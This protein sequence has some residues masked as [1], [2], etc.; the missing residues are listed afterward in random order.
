MA[1]T[2]ITQGRVCKGFYFNYYEDINEYPLLRAAMLDD[3]DYQIFAKKKAYNAGTFTANGVTTVLD[4]ATAKENVTKFV[5]AISSTTEYLEGK[6]S[7]IQVY[8]GPSRLGIKVYGANWPATKNN[9]SGEYAYWDLNNPSDRSGIT[10][11][12]INSHK[13]EYA[14]GINPADNKYDY[15][16]YTDDD[17]NKK[18]EYSRYVLYYS[19]VVLT[20]M[21]GGVPTTVCT[22]ANPADKDS[23]C[24]ISIKNTNNISWRLFD[25]EDKLISI[26]Q[27]SYSNYKNAH[28]YYTDRPVKTIVGVIYQGNKDN[29]ADIGTQY[30]SPIQLH[31]QR[32]KDYKQAVT[33]LIENKP[34]IISRSSDR[35]EF[36]TNYDH[37]KFMVL[38]Y[39]K[40][41]GWKLY[42]KFV[43]TLENGKKHIRK[44]EVT[45][46]KAQ[47]GFIGFETGTGEYTYILE[48]ESPYLNIAFYAEGFG[49]L[50]SLFFFAYYSMRNK[51]KAKAKILSLSYQGE[52]YI[53]QANWDY[54]DCVDNSI[55]K[56]KNNKKTK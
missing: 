40:Q 9:P 52:E 38:N 39:P 35:I 32:N 43:E 24:Y 27:H 10:K 30:S 54:L 53:K 33:N 8:T 51:Q 7:P 3:E 20:P 14:N 55:R 47:G 23:G 22:N 42:R 13:L 56:N 17:G 36:K 11:E 25:E 48:Y 6:T 29:P 49:I 50:V 37:S 19:K 5:S 26:G 4:G 16:N 1:D 34:E 28:G 46:Y 18:E 45:Q 2:F 31:V 12:W 44:V 21:K 41:N 15:Y